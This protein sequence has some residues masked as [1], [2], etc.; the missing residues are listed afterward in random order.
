MPTHDYREGAEHSPHCPMPAVFYVKGA[1]GLLIHLCS[2]CTTTWKDVGAEMIGMSPAGQPCMCLW[3]FCNT[4][5]RVLG[6]A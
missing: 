2:A 1:G 6:V 5:Q 3:D 4:R